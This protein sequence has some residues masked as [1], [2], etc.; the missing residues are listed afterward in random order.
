VLDQGLRRDVCAEMDRVLAPG[1]TIVSVD[2]FVDNPGN[3]S[4]GALKKRELAALLPGYEIGWRRIMLA[5]PLVRRLAPRA[6]WLA[7][8]LQ[9]ARVFDTHAVAVLSRR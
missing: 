5:P 1:G 9:S 4:V 8:L 6:W 2:F 3:A 7:S